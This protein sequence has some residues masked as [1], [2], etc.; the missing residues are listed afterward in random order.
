MKRNTGITGTN[1]TSSDLEGGQASTMHQLLQS[2][3]ERLHLSFHSLGSIARQANH[4]STFP[5]TRQKPSLHLAREALQLFRNITHHDRLC[6]ASE[7]GAFY[8][9]QLFSQKKQF[10]LKRKAELRVQVIKYW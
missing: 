4:P 7:V 5:K 9:Q 2:L 1:R 3:A 8:L 10:S 6:H